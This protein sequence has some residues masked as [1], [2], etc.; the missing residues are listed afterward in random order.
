[1]RGAA[2]GR[3]LGTHAT[4]RRPRRTLVASR[5]S[6]TAVRAPGAND[7]RREGNRAVRGR[8]S[9]GAAGTGWCS[10]TDQDKHVVA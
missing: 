5:H 10:L 1:M 9:V 6:S 2:P 3:V 4:G 8:S 7:S